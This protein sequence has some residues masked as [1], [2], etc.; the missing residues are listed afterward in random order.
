MGV[1]QEQILVSNLNQIA[2]SDYEKQWGAED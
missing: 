1:T 2:D